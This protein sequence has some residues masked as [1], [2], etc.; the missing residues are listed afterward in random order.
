MMLHAGGSPKKF[1]GLTK[2]CASRM[3]VVGLMPCSTPPCER[4][5]KPSATASATMR[6]SSETERIASSLPG[7]AK[8]M[9]IKTS[10]PVGFTKAVTMPITWP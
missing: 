4:L 6:V 7:T 5:T 10:W 3:G 9:P 2:Y 1:S 8:A